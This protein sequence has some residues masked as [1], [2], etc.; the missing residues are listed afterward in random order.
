M[1]IILFCSGSNSYGTSYGSFRSNNYGNS[2]TI[3]TAEEMSFIKEKTNGFITITWAIN[4]FITT[5][6]V[7]WF[8]IVLLE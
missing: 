1:L 6:A 4:I 3:S 5:Y 7:F 8:V 2:V